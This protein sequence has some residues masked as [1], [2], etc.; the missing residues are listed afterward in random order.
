MSESPPE[1]LGF[2]LPRAAK[3]S[4]VGVLAAL[5]AVVGGAFTFGYFQHRKAHGEVPVVRGD[6]TLKVE[7]VKP[8]ALTS[9]R[10]LALPGVVR[11]LEETKLY[12]RTQGYVRRWLVDLGDKVKEGQVLAEID[13]PDVDAQLAQARA[14]LA[15]ARAAV[16]QATAQRDYSKSNTA[17]YQTLADQK[18]VAN[19]QVEQT[20][21]Q[22]ATD[23]A[24]VSA[25][26]SSVAA[27]EANVRRLVDL[28]AFSKIVS[29]FAGTVTTRSIE[30]GALVSETT[31]LYTI[32]ALDPVRILIDVPQT[33]AP[34]VKVGTDAAITV[35]EYGARVFP[36]KV[37]RSAGA[38]D[39]ELHVMTTE[40]RV[41]NG[42]GALMPGMY[43]QAALTLS[44]PHRVLDVPATALYS[45]AQGVRVAIVDAGSKIHFVPI[46]VERDTGAT[47]WVAGGL[48]GDERIVKI[49]IP[50]LV[51]GDAVEVTV[52][53]AA[54]AGSA[55]SKPTP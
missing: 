44:T 20:K 11:P 43:V 28:Q 9:D 5:V 10:A 12:P 41:P 54:P 42:D 8:G 51:E 21:A 7:V 1:D 35:R 32:A 23:E 29:P 50:T 13:I 55:A 48:T 22:A 47:L 3:G 6:S 53:A 2:E 17:R 40:L 27:Q 19:A 45:D 34:S 36:G 24:T 49:A 52:A 38:L 14:Q 30:R 33:V 25:N 37:T 4:R 15:Q 26:E 31:P 39:P 16:K 46:T 18:L